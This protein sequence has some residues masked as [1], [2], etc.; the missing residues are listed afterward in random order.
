MTF[1]DGARFQSDMLVDTDCERADD[2]D[3]AVGR[4]YDFSK[5]ENNSDVDSQDIVI[6]FEDMNTAFEKTMEESEEGSP[7]KSAK[8]A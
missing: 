1:L 5:L 2:Y 6:I 3:V 8:K 7:K 4:L